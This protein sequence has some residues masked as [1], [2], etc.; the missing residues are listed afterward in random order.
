MTK[1][2]ASSGVELRRESPTILIITRHVVTDFNQRGIVQ[3]GRSE[4]T[5]GSD[6]LQQ[7]EE[8]KDALLHYNID[9]VYSSDMMRCRQTIAPYVAAS[10]V[11]VIYDRDLRERDYG[12]FDGVAAEVYTKWKDENHVRETFN[13]SPPEGESF[14]GHIM[15]RVSRALN[16]IL[17]NEQGRAVLVCGHKASNIALLL[18]I[19]GQKPENDYKNYKLSNASITIVKVDGDGM[20]ELVAMNRIGH[21]SSSK[22]RERSKN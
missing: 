1:D 11:R 4:T 15:P 9:A 17:R 3:G 16:R 13:Y 10:N 19:F 2:E 20:A 8:L 12:V 7:A 14:N 5:A 21:L 18:N 22:S 6:G